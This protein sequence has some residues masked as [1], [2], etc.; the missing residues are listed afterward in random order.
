MLL[1]GKNSDYQQLINH[2]FSI[3]NLASHLLFDKVRGLII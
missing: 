3:S 1:N 2:H